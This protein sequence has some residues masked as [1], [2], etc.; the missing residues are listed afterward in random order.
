MVLPQIPTNLASST[1][2]I[3]NGPR[4]DLGPTGGYRLGLVTKSLDH[5]LFIVILSYIIMDLRLIL[6]LSI[7]EGNCFV[8]A[9]REIGQIW[10][11]TDNRKRRIVSLA[12]QHVSIS[13]SEC[14]FPTCRTA[15]LRQKSV[16]DLSN[17]RYGSSCSIGLELAIHKLSPPMFSYTTDIPESCQLTPR[18]TLRTDGLMGLGTQSRQFQLVGSRCSCFPIV[19]SACQ[20]TATPPSK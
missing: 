3:K 4:K 10:N 9:F 14:A 11:A 1:S 17:G 6:G 7:I 16:V 13:L 8:V 18:R 2:K 12:Y 15:Q 19:N 5:D 20:L